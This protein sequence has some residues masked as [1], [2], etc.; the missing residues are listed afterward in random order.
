MFV[1]L[2]IPHG[3]CLTKITRTCDWRAVECSKIIAN[4]LDDKHIKH[5]K[6]QIHIARLDLDANRMKPK[7]ITKKQIKK[8]YELPL[9]YQ[10]TK[11]YLPHTIKASNTMVSNTSTPEENNNMPTQETTIPVLEK[12]NTTLDTNI[13]KITITNT[14]KQRNNV[15]QNITYG[16]YVTYGKYDDSDMTNNKLAIKY[17]NSFNNRIIRIIKEERAKNHKILLLDVHSFPKGSFNGAQIAIIDI[18]KKN[19][20]K[21]DQFAAYMIDKLHLDIRVFNG[22]DNHIQNTYSKSTYP[23]LLEFCEDK[24]YLLHESIKVFCEEL[25]EYFKL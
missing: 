16:K 8:S 6:V 17:W 15:E 1:L 23:L 24:N 14:T 11:S 7:K 9:G 18:Y 19:R 3:F 5:K 4:I 22:L 2:T 13:Q 21:L 12:N 25:V 10:R 20:V